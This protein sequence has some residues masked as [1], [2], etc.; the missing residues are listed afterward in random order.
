MSKMDSTYSLTEADL[1]DAKD[2]TRRLNEAFHRKDLDAATA[3]FWN[4]PDL[5]IVL[6]GNVHSGPDAARAS[7]K[8]MFDQNE[9]I[10]VE[11]NEITYIPSGDGIIG[12]GTAT[13]EYKP[14]DGPARL[15]V[16]RWSDLRKKID[17][18]WVMVLDHT[19]ILP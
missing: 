5:V 16:E 19:T 10:K 12:V 2:L 13:F 14:V 9:S 4:D 15:T 18:Q 6:N 3:C 17:G 1:A 7:I 8:E 11:T